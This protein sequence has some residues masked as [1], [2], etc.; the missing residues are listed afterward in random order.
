[1]QDD[2][3]EQRAAR[4]PQAPA[5]QELAEEAPVFVDRLGALV[6]QQV[7]DHVDADKT[8]EQEAGDGHDDLATDRR[9]QECRWRHRGSV[10][11]GLGAC[12]GVSVVAR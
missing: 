6:E 1:V 7:P 11:D 8:D 12:E 10:L 5:V 9:R 2:G 4:D 3:G